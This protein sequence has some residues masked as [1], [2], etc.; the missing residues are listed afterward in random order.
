MTYTLPAALRIA[1]AE[2]FVRERNTAL[3]FY[4]DILG[5]RL[6]DDHDDRL[7]LSAD[8]VTPLLILHVRPGWN[9]PPRQAT[10]LYHMAVRL[11]DRPAL[12]RV[13]YRLAEQQ[14]PFSGFSDHAVSE[15]LYLDDPEG[16]GLELYRDRPR[17]EWPRQG[18]QV[19]MT[20]A[21]LDAQALLN[22]AD[23]APWTG[24]DPGTDIGHMHLHVG[25]LSRARGFYVDT[26]GFALT[27]DWSRHGALFVAA[28][29]Y[30][31]HL[32]LNT[33]NGGHPQPPETLGLKA[34]TLA[35]PDA[36]A[37]D[38]L[39]TQLAAHDNPIDSMDAGGF[40]VAGPDGHRLHW[41]MDSLRVGATP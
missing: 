19:L 12:A 35:L 11:P 5:L 36:A 26:L 29:D 2:L 9:R 23:P 28:G 30:H 10:A 38:A 39:R 16:N 40:I 34:F 3:R 20:T 37:L 21:A 15:A 1:T 13:L 33:W 17:A 31:H 25:D 22:E 14:V 41:M 8:G 18:D 7:T 6:L 32:G 27:S 4:R 24:I